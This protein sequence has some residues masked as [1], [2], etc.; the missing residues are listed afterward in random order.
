MEETRTAFIPRKV[1]EVRMISNSIMHMIV[2]SD[3]TQWRGRNTAAR[4]LQP[5]IVDRRN[6][7]SLYHRL[8]V[9]HYIL[10]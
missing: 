8:A 9:R 3:M 6:I 7:F 5:P 2:A 10:L 4:A 1:W